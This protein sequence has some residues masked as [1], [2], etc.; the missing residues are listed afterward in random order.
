[1][2][3]GAGFLQAVTE[4]AGAKDGEATAQKLIIDPEEGT[5]EKADLHAGRLTASTSLGGAYVP[6]NESMTLIPT[7]TPPLSSQIQN[8]SS[9][10]Q[11]SW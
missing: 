10:S 7:F 2:T 9:S 5:G 3:R 1:M 4:A 8:S 11:A 6:S